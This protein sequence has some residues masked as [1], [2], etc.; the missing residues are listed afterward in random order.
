[1]A[2]QPIVDVTAQLSDETPRRNCSAY[3]TKG[4]VSGKWR[5]LF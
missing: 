1:M 2:P 3:D 5:V 4:Y